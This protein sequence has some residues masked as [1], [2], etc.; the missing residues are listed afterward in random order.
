MSEAGQH[1]YIEQ[2]KTDTLQIRLLNDALEDVTLSGAQSVQIL[3]PGGAVLLALTSAGVTVSGNVATL[4]QAWPEAIA[5]PADNATN[6]L[7]HMN[8]QRVSHTVLT[9]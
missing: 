8:S 1:Q 9:S 4:S 5:I 2:N 6:C 3:A 7:G